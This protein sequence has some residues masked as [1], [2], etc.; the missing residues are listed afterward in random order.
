MSYPILPERRG[1]VNRI[2]PKVWLVCTQPLL[3]SG[4]WQN[5]RISHSRYVFQISLQVSNLFLTLTVDRLLISRTHTNMWSRSRGV[6][7]DT[8]VCV[9]AVCEFELQSR[10][11]VHIRTLGNSIK[12]LMMINGDARGVMVIVVETRRHEFK[13]WTDCISH[14]TNTLGKGMNPI[15]LPPAMGK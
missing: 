11:Y 9:I 14:S 3:L 4:R 12:S 1:W 5:F 6:I 7:S 8:L 2:C 10:N 13:S 15:I